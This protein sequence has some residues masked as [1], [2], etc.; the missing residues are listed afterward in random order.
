[1]GQR[2]YLTN[3]L[4]IKELDRPIEKE[5]VAIVSTIWFITIALIVILGILKA[6]K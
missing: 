2:E 1:M 4:E 6:E 3:S 5:D